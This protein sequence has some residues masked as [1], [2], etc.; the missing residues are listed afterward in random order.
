M[1]RMVNGWDGGWLA[2]LNDAG[3]VDALAGDDAL[4]AIGRQGGCLTDTVAR[5]TRY[6]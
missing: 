6:S 4:D 3:S 5:L 2:R 1:T